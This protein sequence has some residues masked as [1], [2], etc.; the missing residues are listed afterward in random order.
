MIA[1][2]WLIWCAVHFSSPVN[3]CRQEAVTTACT[4]GF[5]IF[6][7]FCC[8]QSIDFCSQLLASLVHFTVVKSQAILIIRLGVTEVISAVTLYLLP[9]FSSTSLDMSRLCNRVYIL[10]IFNFNLLIIYLFYFI[11]FCFLFCFVS[12]RFIL[13]YFIL[14]Y[15]ILFYFIFL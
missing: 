10:Y 3:F 8:R 12:F 15:F 2:K 1:L 13:F 7:K 4:R 14:L 9:A 11:L 6:A 5:N